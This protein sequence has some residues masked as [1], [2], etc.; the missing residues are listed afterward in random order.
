VLS[1]PI[2]RKEVKLAAGNKSFTARCPSYAALLNAK[3]RRL[4]DEH[5]TSRHETRGSSLH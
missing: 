1:T 5:K 3:N 2:Y 4:A